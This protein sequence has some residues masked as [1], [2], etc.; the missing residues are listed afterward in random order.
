MAS[1]TPI[2]EQTLLFLRDTPQS[3]YQSI[4][5]S[6]GVTI[7]ET[8]YSVLENRVRSLLSE[9]QRLSVFLPADAMGFVQTPLPWPARRTLVHE[10]ARPTHQSFIPVNQSYYST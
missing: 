1:F 4:F 9:S 10:Y 3:S 6:F 5:K 2:P 8:K 7:K